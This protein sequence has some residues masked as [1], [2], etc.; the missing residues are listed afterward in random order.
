MRAIHLHI[1]LPKTASTWLQEQAFPQ[2]RHLRVVC[3]PRSRL[4]DEPADRALEGRVMACAM[5]RS[6]GVWRAMGDAVMAEMLG[7]RAASLADGRDLLISDEAIGR[8]GSRP[9]QLAAHLR[10]MAPVAARWGFERL[11]VI[12]LI[13]RQDRWIASHYAQMSDRNPRASQRDFEAFAARLA[14]PSGARF[15]LGALLDYAALREALAA[16][17]PDPLVL[18]HEAL[19]RAPAEALRV[20]LDRLG[21]PVADR[22]RVEAASLGTVANM[23]SG[24]GS[25]RL[26]P[27][28]RALLGHPRLAL[29][30]W[31]RRGTITLTPE[32]SARVMAAYAEGNRALDAAAGLGLA[33]LGYFERDRPRPADPWAT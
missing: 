5:R 18:A 7:P 23:R 6:A 14:D 9:E 26:R 15:A 25:W 2:L 20:L 29:P 21:T 3:T 17:A 4:F 27:R 11:A 19:E 30:E 16:V 28:R 10:E 32:I 24:G 31:G 22:E 33:E 13:R 12:C 1:G 8:V